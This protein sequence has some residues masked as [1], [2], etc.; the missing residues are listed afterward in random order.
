MYKISIIIPVYNTEK[1]LERCF[2]SVCK[3]E[4]LIPLE[5][6]FVN[7]GSTDNS[8][9]VLNNYKDNFN[10]VKVI[11][12]NNQGL[13]VARNTGIHHARSDYFMLLDSDD[14]LNVHELA[15]IHETIV[16]KEINFI[17]FGL[18]Y[19]DQNE[20]FTGHRTNQPVKHNQ[21]FTGVEF[22]KQGYQPSSAC[23]FIF[24]TDFVKQN[25][26]FFKKGIMQEDVEFTLRMFLKAKSGIFV[27]TYIYNYYRHD[28]SMTITKDQPRLKR[29]LS[30][31]ISVAYLIKQNKNDLTNINYFNLIE[32]N[33]NSVTWNLLWR[34]ISKPNEVD[35]D[36]KA[37]CIRE[38]KEKNLY[39]IKGELK[40][41][42]QKLSTI[43][44]NREFFLKLLFKLL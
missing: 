6:I 27:N 21:V 9:K 5:V 23:L 19:Y 41:N 10:F 13:S 2:E 40:T 17:S 12:Q 7:D 38:L 36:F 16:S 22:L 14:W 44:F 29:Y 4:R 1:Y 20:N 30:D 3:L 32:Q 31:S 43:L 24:E 33:Y 26:L 28:N 35:Y 37:Q 42:F 34:F 18:S 8:L 25:E 11:T 15:N 39:P